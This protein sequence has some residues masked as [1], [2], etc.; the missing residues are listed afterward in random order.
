[1]P[2]QEPEPRSPLTVAQYAALKR[3]NKATVYRSVA[4]GKRKAERYGSAIRIPP[5]A[6]PTDGASWCRADAG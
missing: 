5:D 3:L 4:A 6:C 1:M 2:V